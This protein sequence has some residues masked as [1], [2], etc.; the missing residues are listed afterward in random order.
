MDSIIELT[1]SIGGKFIEAKQVGSAKLKAFWETN[2]FDLMLVVSWRYLLPT[3]IY[4]LP[5]LGTFVFHDALLPAYR[6]FSPTVWAIL[7]GEKQTGISIITVVDKI[8]AGERAELDAAI[9]AEKDT[10]V[11]LNIYK[12][13]K[14]CILR[15]E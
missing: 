6:G 12:A 3:S 7:N 8:D 5:R 4:T 1:E 15:G 11:L 14:N 2:E 10:S 9:V 13:A